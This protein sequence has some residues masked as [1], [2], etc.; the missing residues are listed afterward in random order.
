M[1]DNN[2][3]PEATAPTGTGPR[4]DEAIK[5]GID[6][7][8]VQ[9]QFELRQPW[10]IPT[11]GAATEAE[12]L[13]HSLKSFSKETGDLGVRY[14]A[15]EGKEAGATAALGGNFQAKTGLQALT[16]YGQNFNAS[17]H[18]VYLSQTQTSIM[19]AN[20]AAMQAYKNDPIGYQTEMQAIRKATLE[21]T[22]SLYKPEIADLFDKHME[23]GRN[24]IQEDTIKQGQE[25]A[26][27]AVRTAQPYII[28]K[29]VKAAGELSD[30]KATAL[31]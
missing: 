14:A 13:A 10:H 7:R 19:T 3:M 9:P 11:S 26:I 17:G 16:A 5:P 12:E 25:D 1:A 21:E 24:R 20:D 23:A 18:V 6:Y 29:T 27:N 22:P 30:E 8:Q 28:D 4:G 2:L 31:I 15:Q